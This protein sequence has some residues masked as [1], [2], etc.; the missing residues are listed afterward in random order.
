MENAERAQAAGRI[1]G[2]GETVFTPPHA[3]T[4]RTQGPLRDMAHV[5]APLSGGGGGGSR[6]GGGGGGWA[7][8]ATFATTVIWYG[9][10][11][12]AAIGTKNAVRP[13]AALPLTGA[14]FSVAAVSA[15]QMAGAVVVAAALLIAQGRGLRAPL[16][17]LTAGL[18][19]ATTACHATGSAATVAASLWATASVV[20]SLKATEP[21]FAVLL[22]GDPADAA[23]RKLL[24]VIM[25]VVAGALCSGAQLGAN[26]ATRAGVA[27]VV[28]ALGSNVAL[29]SRNLLSKRFA[30]SSGSRCAVP[31][32]GQVPPGHDGVSVLLHESAVSGAGFA[33]IAAA[34]YALDPAVAARSWR[35]GDAAFLNAVA[36]SSIGFGIYQC[37]SSLLLGR[38][39]A[40]THALVNV[41][42]RIVV[43]AAA[44]AYFGPPPDVLTVGSFAVLVLGLALHN[45]HV[46]R[47]VAAKLGA[48][49]VMAT[50]AEAET[51]VGEMGAP[52]AAADR[53]GGKGE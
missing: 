20:Q 5:V 35:G 47:Y 6:G 52:A 17:A 9:A 29:A 51:G 34:I 27:S 4:V 30:A 36:A 46:V 16:V 18:P 49:G 37:A 26:I 2:S 48:G 21:V 32:G 33:S 13:A 22:A 11:S 43:V 8:V 7:L 50:A 44:A 19:L 3:T 45:D 40:V 24:A 10:T 1:G 15:L 28:L 41:G 23:P 38:L 14:L 12:F 53:K 25:V 39:S 31:G 42:K